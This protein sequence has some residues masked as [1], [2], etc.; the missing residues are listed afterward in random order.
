MF[1]SGFIGIIGRPNVGKST[2]F[3]AIIGEKVSIIAD[4]PQTTRN[5][6]TGIRNFP[7]AQLVFLDTPGIH[8]AKTLLNRAMVQ[9]ARESMDDADILLML[10]DAHA[11]VHPQDLFLI[12]T[13]GEVKIPVFLVINKIDLIE[14][15]LL[16]P[17]ID[18]F[19]ALYDFR[20]IFP[21]SAAKEYGLDELLQTIKDVLP[22]GPQ[23]FAEDAFTD[24]TERF[25]AAEFIREKIMVLT[26]QEVPY[27]TAVVI[28]SFKEE[29][30]K[31]LIR[32]SATITVE[33]ESQK[34]IM[35]GKKGSMLKSIGTQ[36]RLEME[37]L[38]GTRVFLELFVRVKKDWTASDKM[39]HEFGLIKN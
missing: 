34:A 19:R 2:L 32:V 15:P 23:Y 31:N 18:K 13:L 35:I 3:N 27:A 1:K 10:A 16:L 9:T 26:A 21:V 39:L 6:I 22:E 17:L 30:A 25:I 37:K 28:D 33:K 12:E 5:K 4:K 29:E 24:A 7:D 11:G 8:K 36:A 38:F 20:E 14:K